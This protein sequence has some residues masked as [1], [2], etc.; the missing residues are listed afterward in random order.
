MIHVFFG[1]FHSHNQKQ[2]PFSSN[3]IMMCSKIQIADVYVYL[4]FSHKQVAI[5]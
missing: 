5:F 1:I 3:E 2:D 4:L